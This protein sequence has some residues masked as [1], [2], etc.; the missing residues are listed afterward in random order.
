MSSKVESDTLAFNT[1]GSLLAAYVLLHDLKSAAG[2]PGS[3][4]TP[5]KGVLML[6]RP[7]INRNSSLFALLSLLAVLLLV[8]CGG[9]A[10]S[11][12]PSTP[13]A[14]SSAATTSVTLKHMPF[15]TADL[16]WNPS[17]RT[18]MGRFS[19]FGL[20]P[21]STHPTQIYMGS[22]NNLGN[23][24]YTLSNVV[25]D[26][27]G[28]ANTTT[29]TNSVPSGIPATG[30]AI[31]VHNGPGL[32]TA[33]QSLPILCANVVNAHPS[34]T[35]T[36]SVHIVMQSAPRSSPSETVNGMAQ[37]TLSGSTL[38]V[39]LTVSG[40]EPNSSHAAHIHTGSCASQGPVIYP[41]SSLMANAQGN[42]STTTTIPKVTSIPSSGWYVN[43]HHSTNLST[44]IGYDPIA[45]G[46]VIRK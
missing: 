33:D 12:P 36:Q 17:N 16:S 18:L 30:W 26:G 24:I 37:L 44:Q 9:G 22:C 25:A 31:V 13:T 40:L 2:E 39:K 15:G 32:S 21:S 45:C 34:T 10:T 28:V 20:A 27:H 6:T 38:T 41:L 14:A 42:A 43:V 3:G 8:A 35:T 11:A 7:F 46:D 1:P 4:R 23:V 19:L 5:Q 29:S